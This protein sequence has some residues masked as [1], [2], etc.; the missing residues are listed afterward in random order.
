MTTPEAESI[1]E[2]AAVLLLKIRRASGRSM[3]AV[4]E[5]RGLTR[6]EWKRVEEQDAGVDTIEKALAA[7]RK[8]LVVEDWV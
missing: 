7:C 5:E 4:A 8:R 3:R 1:R 6:D 2:R